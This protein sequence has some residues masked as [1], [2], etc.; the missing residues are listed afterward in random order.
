MLSPIIT[1]D[2]LLT[3]NAFALGLGEYDVVLVIGRG[4][5]NR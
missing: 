5:I 2:Y 4:D 3:D 1:P